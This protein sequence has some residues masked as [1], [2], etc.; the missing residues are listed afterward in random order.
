MTARVEQAV[1]DDL[2]ASVSLVGLI[3]PHVALRRHG[4]EHIGLCPFHNERTPSF[5][6]NEQ[7]GFA[8]CFGCGWHGRHLDFIMRY[9]GLSF[10]DALQRLAD[11]SGFRLDEKINPA[12][13]ERRERQ[14]RERAVELA[15]E[16][17]AAMD[18]ARLIF[19]GGRHPDG[20]PGG[21]HLS[22]IRKIDLRPASVVYT[23]DADMLAEIEKKR[24]G[25][26]VAMHNTVSGKFSAIQ[27]V[28]LNRDGS[29]VKIKDPDSGKMK[30]LKLSLGCVRGAAA[31]LSQQPSADGSWGL[32]EGFETAAACV[33]LYSVPTWAAISSGNMQNIKPPSWAKR[34]NIYADNDA[35]CAGYKAAMKARDAWIAAGCFA[36]D[37]IHIFMVDEVGK[38]HA[39]L[40][41]AERAA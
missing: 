9:S 6:V 11:G 25:L 23:D 16:E 27:R 39:D 32:A 15:A 3:S 29:P 2:L 41:L 26:V 19:K 12:E 38:D 20:T 18:R 33:Q 34:A 35:N 7:K 10:P 4:R 40:L 17:A 13:R 1:I 14:R 31:M 36:A 8:H 24:A 37:D 28:Y 30:S 21:I 5:T 22:N